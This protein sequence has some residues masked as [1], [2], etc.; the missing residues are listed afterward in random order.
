[1]KSVATE[2]TA[3]A[4]EGNTVT[5]AAGKEK[6]A[7]IQPDWWRKTFAGGVL[8]LALAYGLVG[9]F[10]W[11]GPGGINAG[12]KVQFNMWMVAL[13]WLTV[14]SLTYLFRTGNRAL[15]F[16]GGAAAAAHLLLVLVRGVML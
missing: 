2:Q 1:M 14:F 3:R 7:K 11:A 16:L 15:L 12:D 5:A 10:A 6:A 9:I 4:A 8:G 13:I